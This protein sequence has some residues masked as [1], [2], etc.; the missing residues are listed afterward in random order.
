MLDFQESLTLF[1]LS[2]FD[3]DSPEVGYKELSRRAVAYC[4]GVPLA[5]I[6][7]GSFLHSKDEVEWDSALKKNRED[8]QG[9]NSKCVKI[10]L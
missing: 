3:E 5:L 8:S 9:G 6:V 1:S 4:K 7:L 2:A 10:E